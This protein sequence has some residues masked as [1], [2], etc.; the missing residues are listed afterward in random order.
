VCVLRAFRGE[1]RGLWETAVQWLTWT[2]ALAALTPIAHLEHAPLAEVARLRGVT[3]PHYHRY[4]W[5]A[6]WVGL[7][8]QFG[9]QCALV[10]ALVAW[11]SPGNPV[12][13]LL[14]TLGTSIALAVGVSTSLVLLRVLGQWLSPPSPRRLLVAAL[15]VPSLLE[16][17]IDLPSVQSS[18]AW[19]ARSSGRAVGL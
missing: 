19:L 17:V 14:T 15:L 4:A 12:T 10:A 7:F 9:I 18:S 2:T 8:R 6:L 13:T 16:G 11:R 3:S 5:F 1:P